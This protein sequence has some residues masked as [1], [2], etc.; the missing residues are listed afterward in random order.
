MANGVPKNPLPRERAVGSRPLVEFNTL[1]AGIAIVAA[2]YFGRDIFVPL[3]IAIL[4]S[5]A[6]GPVVVVLRRFRLGRIPSVV[7]AVLLAALV[8]SGIGMVVGSQ[9]GVLAENVQLYQYNIAEKVGSLRAA[10]AGSSIVNRASELMDNLGSEISN[11]TDLGKTSK[12]APANPPGGQQ[13]APIPVEIHQPSATTLEIIETIVGPLLQPLATAGI[14]IVFVIFFLLQRE[15][16]RD[17]FIRLVGARDLHR[18]TRGLDD[19]AHRVSRYLLAQTAIN[20]SFGV[21][22]GAG[23]GIIGVPNA[24]LWGMIAMLLRFVPYIGPFIAAVFPAALAV[25]VDPGWSMLLW[26]VVLFLV[27]EGAIG[28]IVE[29]LLYGRSTGLSPVAVVMAAAFWTWLWGPVGLLLSTPLTLCLV[30]VGRHV[31]RLE[32][33][34]IILGDQPA[35]TLEENFYQRMLANDP[36]EAARQAELVLKEKPLAAY[37]DEVVIAGLALAQLDVNR[38]VLEHERRVQIK[39]AVLDVVDD[40]SDHV[41]AEVQPNRVALCVAGQG[42]LDEAAAALLAQLLENVGIAARVVPS[43]AVMATSIFRLDVTD[44]RAVCL[45]YIDPGGVANARYLVRRIRRRIP[46]VPVGVGFWTL[47]T[48]EAQERNALRETDADFVATSLRQAALDVAKLAG[49]PVRD[50]T[51]ADDALWPAQHLQIPEADA[52][53]ARGAD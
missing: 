45:S 52:E 31:E 2:L 33:L 9:V 35:L 27:V 20:A 15:D 4:L 5:F 48:E 36:D 7:A 53:A 37:Y 3:A 30:V 29:P 40:L 18:T 8:I 12:S 22:I 46:E 41:T 6:L 16:L 24:V 49:V 38:G 10:T 25:A 51:P 23:L 17:R 42:S 44:V 50:E 1:G 21:L 39:E 34:D 11:A 19:A 26:T 32:F 43:S 13:R 47:N 14:V 28:Q